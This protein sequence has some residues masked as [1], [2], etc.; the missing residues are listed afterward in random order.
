MASDAPLT[1]PPAA[2]SGPPRIWPALV[3]V[4]TAPIVVFGSVY[5]VSEVFY[6][7][8][9]GVVERLDH[10][11][12]FNRWLNRSLYMLA[13]LL[14]TS[15][16]I[17][18]VALIPAALSPVTWW[19]RLGLVKTRMPIWMWVLML[20]A[21]LFIAYAIYLVFPGLME[22]PPE[23][24]TVLAKMIRE[25]SPGQ[26][27]LLCV[28]ISVLPGLAEELLYRGYVQRRLLQRWPAWA[29]I[30]L[31]A[32]AFAVMHP[33]PRHMAATLIP[34]IWMGAVAWYAGSIWPAIAC[35]MLNNLLFV[36]GTWF[37]DSDEAFT[38]ELTASDATWLKISALALFAFVAAAVI[39][40]RAGKSP[41]AVERTADQ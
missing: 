6:A 24:V 16:V 18:L 15:T 38:T 33:D 1:Y 2:S 27:V 34:G 3:V 14:P 17:A 21:H 22:N 32:V 12:P 29:A 36:L 4:L 11:D 37:S 9:S 19:K 20:M 31:P 40:H 8:Y 30:L 25:S 10:A 7:V 41:I 5:L 28:L 39:R 26:L 35:H 13:V 23:W